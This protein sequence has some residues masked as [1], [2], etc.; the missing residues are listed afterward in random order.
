MARISQYQIDASIS[1]N[2][3]LL[4]SDAEN[5]NATKRFTVGALAAYINGE[6]SGSPGSGTVTSVTGT[7]SVSGITLSGE[8]TSSGSLTLGGSLSL[9]SQQVIDFLGYT[10]S[11]FDGDYNNLTNKP[12]LFDGTYN[13]LTGLPTLFDGDYDS[14][15]NQPSLFSGDYADLTNKPTIQVPAI[16]SV[17]G[18]PSLNTGITAEEIRTLIGAGDGSGSIESVTGTAPIVSSGG[19][20]PTISIT[21]ATSSAA[22]SMSAADK[23]KLDGIDD[24]SDNYVKNNTDTFT[25]SVK[26]TQIATLTQSQYDGIG[27]PSG[28]TLYIIL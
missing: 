16:Y 8:V 13:S 11:S 27:T 14:L 5:S 9:T 21:A 22:G 4:G 18:V 15:T 2:D 19:S 20:T 12:S 17:L 3:Q 25:P 7:G 6:S 23:T 24:V 10:P 1:N 26:I 28:S